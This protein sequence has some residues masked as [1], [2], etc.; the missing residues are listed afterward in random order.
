M[1][2]KLTMLRQQKCRENTQ[3]M[4][5]WLKDRRMRQWCVCLEKLATCKHRGKSEET[6]KNTL[7]L[8]MLNYQIRSKKNLEKG[9]HKK[10]KQW[11]KLWRVESIHHLCISLDQAY[12]PLRGQQQSKW[13]Q[14]DYQEGEEHPGSEILC[15]RHL[16]ILRNQLRMLKKS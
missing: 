10:M 7:I 8:K 13:T 12:S 5:E 2:R 14:L 15:L 3:E 11:D 16:K 4:P 6:L 9:S 1:W